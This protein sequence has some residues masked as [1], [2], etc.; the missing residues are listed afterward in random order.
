MQN[1]IEMLLLQGFFVFFAFGFLFQA[2]CQYFK[3]FESFCKECMGDSNCYCYDGINC[4]ANNSKMDEFPTLLKLIPAC[5]HS[6]IPATSSINVHI[7]SYK[8][9]SV[10]AF[11]LQLTAYQIA[12]SIYNNQNLKSTVIISTC[13]KTAGTESKHK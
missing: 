4:F 2:E 10:P 12:V 7:A 3:S 6:S 1:K 9:S 11:A 5:L 8:F 13:W